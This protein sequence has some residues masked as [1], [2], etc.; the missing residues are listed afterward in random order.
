[1]RTGSMRA[2]PP[3][4][5]RQREVAALLVQGMPTH[6]MAKRLF[7]TESTVKNHLHALYGRLGVS[8]RTQA[9]VVLLT[10][11]RGSNAGTRA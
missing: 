3:L 8:S 1:M 11:R 4:T 10:G 2:F 5:V 7:L 9:V 6:T